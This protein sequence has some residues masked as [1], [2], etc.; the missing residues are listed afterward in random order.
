VSNDDSQKI[1][2]VVGSEQKS[3]ADRVRQIQEMQRMMEE[4]ALA[5][6]AVAQATVPVAQTIPTTVSSDRFAVASAQK[7]V[8]NDIKV[9]AR[10]QATYGKVQADAASLFGNNGGVEIKGEPWKIISFL[11]AA[12]ALFE[13]KKPLASYEP[14]LAKKAIVTRQGLLFEVGLKA[15]DGAEPV[16]KRQVLVGQNGQLRGAECKSPA[17]LERLLRAPGFFDRMLGSKPAQGWQA[18]E[19]AS[20]RFEVKV[21]GAQAQTLYFNNFGIEVPPSTNRLA[22]DFIA[23]YHLDQFGAGI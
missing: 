12:P 1:G 20:A 3:P 5:P 21:P 8:L 2:A 14:L 13:T 22:H 11:D 6:A 15:R 9:S 7:A 16:Q 4:A 23:N 17:E 10:E 18:K 19:S